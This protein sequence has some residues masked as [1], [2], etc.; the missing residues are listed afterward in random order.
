MVS[1]AIVT[2]ATQTE[3][4]NPQSLTLDIPSMYQHANCNVS[5]FMSMSWFCPILLKGFP[6]G[7]PPVMVSMP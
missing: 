3:K 2:V 4:Q 5:P 6:Q 1:I 7:V